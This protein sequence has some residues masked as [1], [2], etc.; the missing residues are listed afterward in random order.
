MW[1][2]G[3][4]GNLSLEYILDLRKRRASVAQKELQL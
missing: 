1:D 2:L 3:E 4:R